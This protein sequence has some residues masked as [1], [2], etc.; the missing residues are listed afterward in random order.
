MYRLFVGLDL[1]ADVKQR[2]TLIQGGVPGARW[3]VADTFHLTLRFVGEVDGGVAR[4]ID[5]ALSRISVP[6]L[7]VR[8]AGVGQFG[9]RGRPGMLWAGVPRTEALTRLRDKVERAVQ[10]AGLEPEERKFSPHVTL[11]RLR[12]ADPDRVRSWLGEHA[13]FE[14]GPIPVDRFTL[15]RSHLGSEGAFYEVVEEYALTAGA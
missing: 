7:E 11:A 4:D 6:A 8:L 12:S 5:T 2:L 10:T 9:S 3:L 13:A 15:F 14:A 1:P